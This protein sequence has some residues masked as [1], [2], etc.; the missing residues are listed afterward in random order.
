MKINVYTL[1]YP[2]G[3]KIVHYDTSIFI[4]R[5][6]DY[7]QLH[8][9]AHDMNLNKLHRYSGNASLPHAYKS[10]VKTL[11]SDFIQSGGKRLN[12]VNY[13]ERFD[14]IVNA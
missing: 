11:L 3:N 13:R 4:Q 8:K 9:I 12:L 5:V 1:V 7:N 2:D 14:L 6:N 10:L